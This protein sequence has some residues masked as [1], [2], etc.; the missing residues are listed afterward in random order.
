MFE[1]VKQFSLKNDHENNNKKRKANDE[2]K[3]KT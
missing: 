1:A 2:E 3:T